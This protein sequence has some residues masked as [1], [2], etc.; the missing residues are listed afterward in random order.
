MMKL[1]EWFFF[2]CIKLVSMHEADQ[3][4]FEE[5]KNA[6]EED[7]R[8]RKGDRQGREIGAEEEIH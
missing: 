6:K 4:H 8:D 3:Q 1:G 7:V 2:I 5:K